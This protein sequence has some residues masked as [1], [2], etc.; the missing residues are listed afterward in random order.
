MEGRK[1]ARTVGFHVEYVKAK[2][3]N[4]KDGFLLF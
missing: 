3:A 2:F 4:A 1:E